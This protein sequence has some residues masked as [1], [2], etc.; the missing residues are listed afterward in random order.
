MPISTDNI[1]HF[2]NKI[3]HIYSILSN[4]FRPHFSLEDLNVI[5]PKGRESEHLKFAIPMVSFCDIPLSQTLRHMVAYGEYGIGLKKEW[6]M[7][8]GISPVI[9][10]YQGASMSSKL[11]ELIAKISQLPN[12][13]PSQNPSLDEFHDLSNYVKPYEGKPIHRE[14]K[15][16]TIRYYDEREWRFVPRLPDNSYR[17]GLAEEGFNNQKA[18]DQ[19]NDV[20]WNQAKIQFVP[21]D[22]RYLIVAKEIEILPMIKKIEKLKGTRFGPDDIKVLSS[23]VISAEQIKND[24]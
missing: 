22:I 11:Y 4:D 12:L 3:D 18:I 10:T 15:D 17:Y 8:N 24:F 14:R 21:N 16:M 13:L 7:E 19:A 9:Y 1:F 6:G 5:M 2:T 20:I 23:R